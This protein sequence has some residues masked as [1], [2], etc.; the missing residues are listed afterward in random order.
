MQ[1]R[2][3]DGVNSA[4]AWVNVFSV[5][6]LANTSPYGTFSAIQA[7]CLSLS[8]DLRGEL[9]RGGVRVIN[10]FTGPVDTEWFQTVPPP[11]VAPKAIASAVLNALRTGLEDV[12]VGDV[13]KDIRERLTANPK[14]V[15]REQNSDQTL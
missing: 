12:Y 9:R 13:A 15:E 6:A 11:K 1:G 8:H 4:A 14:A 3:A 10:V 5:F 2:G 7:G